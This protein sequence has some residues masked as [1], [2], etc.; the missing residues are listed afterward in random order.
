[1]NQLMCVV[2][3]YNP[4]ISYFSQVIE[5]ICANRVPVIV[6]D[7]GSS[8]SAELMGLLS[9]SPAI[10]KPLEKNVGIA[11]AQN[12]G[13]EYAISEGASHIWLSDQDTLYSEDYASRMFDAVAQLEVRGEPYGAVGPCFFE[14]NRK[15]VEEFVRFA[16]YAKRFPPKSGLNSVAHLIASGMVIPKEA[17]QN[18][19][20]KRDDFFIDWVDLE[21]CWRAN[22]KGFPVYGFGDVV[23]KHNLGDVMVKVANKSISVRSPFRHYFIIR[24]GLYLFLHDKLLPWEVRIHYLLRTLAISVGYPLLAPTQKWQHLKVN[25]LGLW[26]GLL[27]RLGPKP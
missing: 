2:V 26:H 16:P 10:C 17:F 15:R 24:N 7:N 18:V 12:I 22:A 11:K 9:S 6:V 5:K 4:D 3:T 8:N 14:M 23:I 1:M 13:I 19:G 20:F 27:G 21:W 25:V